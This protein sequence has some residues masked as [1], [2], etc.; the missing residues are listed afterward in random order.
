MRREAVRGPTRSARTGAPAASLTLGPANVGRWI[1]LD[2]TSLVQDWVTT[3]ASNYGLL[4]RPTGG[5]GTVDYTFNLSEH[6][7]VAQRSRLTVLLAAS[8]P[9]PTPTPTATANSGPSCVKVYLEAEQGVLGRQYTTGSDSACS[10]CAYAYVPDGTG[11]N[12][13]SSDTLTFYA[14]E[15]TLYYFW[16]RLPGTGLARLGSALCGGQRSAGDLAVAGRQGRL[17]VGERAQRGAQEVLLRWECAG[18]DARQR[19]AVLPALRPSRLD[20]ADAAEQ[21][22]AR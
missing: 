5:Q 17:D 6:W 12:D 21:R 8:T 3:P 9:A 14:P 19:H 7:E 1:T 10:G 4:L 15:T 13:G 22:H 18:G 16:G 11:Y 20:G 2:V